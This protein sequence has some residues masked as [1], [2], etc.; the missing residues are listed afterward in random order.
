MTYTT[1]LWGAKGGVGTSTVAAGIA[2]SDYRPTTLIDLDGDLPAVLGLREPNGPG[3]TEWF[4]SDAPADALD[5][6]TL[7][8]NPSTRLLPRG[9]QPLN[10]APERWRDLIGW[11]ESHGPVIVDAGVGAPPTPI[12]DGANNILVTRACYL[13]LRR[14]IAEQGH[15]DGVVLVTE[16]GRALGRQDVEAAL[17]TRVI[18]EVSTD[19]SIARM[20]DAGLI[21]G[22]LPPSLQ[23]DVEPVIGLNS[24]TAAVHSPSERPPGVAP[25]EC[26]H[27]QRQPM[28]EPPGIG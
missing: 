28:V 21:S 8:A 13:A 27:A 25:L 5:G 22:R 4:N 19:P 18:A 2:L 15:A 10:A 3:V 14:A 12:P 20:I 1:V 23:R 11:A 9:N 17:G 7:D 24:A 26:V 6:L 16:P